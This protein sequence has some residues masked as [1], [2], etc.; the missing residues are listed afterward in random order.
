MCDELETVEIINTLNDSTFIGNKGTKHNIEEQNI[1][2][3]KI[4]GR[5]RN[6]T[7]IQVDESTCL[8]HI[9]GYNNSKDGFKERMIKKGTQYFN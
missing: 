5:I 9:H 7:V 2:Q 6:L 1:V 8:L 4:N 3:A